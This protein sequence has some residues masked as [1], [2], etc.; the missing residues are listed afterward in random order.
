M[1][2]CVCR[3]LPCCSPLSRAL[4]TSCLAFEKQTVPIIAWPILTGTKDVLFISHHHIASMYIGATCQD[5]LPYV[6]P[7][8]AADNL[9][10]LK[11]RVTLQATVA[12]ATNTANT[13]LLCIAFLCFAEFFP[14]YP[15]CIV[16]FSL[17]CYTQV[18]RVGVTCTKLHC[19]D[20]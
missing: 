16:R 5:I 4:Q 3:V 14:Q 7:Y 10:Q 20:R 19:S 6:L 13:L 15:E 18:A 8:A 17:Q 1:L 11:A 12:T 2:R 9:I